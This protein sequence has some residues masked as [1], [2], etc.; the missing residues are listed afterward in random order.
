MLKCHWGWRGG[1]NRGKK[2]SK[3]KNIAMKKTKGNLKVEHSLRDLKRR[4]II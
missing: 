4:G 3:V 1:E 2:D